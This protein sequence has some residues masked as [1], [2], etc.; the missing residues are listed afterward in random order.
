MPA[1]T[2][3]ASW[4]AKARPA[5][6]AQ[7]RGRGLE[8]L[9][10]WS[11]SPRPVRPGAWSSR[12]RPRGRG[13]RLGRVASA[14]RARRTRRRR[15]SWTPECRAPAQR[16]AAR[17]C[18]GRTSPPAARLR[19]VTSPGASCGVSRVTKARGGRGTRV[20]FVTSPK[21]P[22]DCTYEGEAPPAGEGPARRQTAAPS[23]PRPSTDPRAH[24]RRLGSSLVAD[25]SERPLGPRR[26]AR[27]HREGARR[28]QAADRAARPRG[29]GRRAR[30]VG[31]PGEG[32]GGHQPA[33][34]GAGR[35]HPGRVLPVPARRP[36]PCCSRWPPRR[37]TRPTPPRPTPS[38]PPCSGRSAASRCARCCRG[39]TT[40]ARRSCRSRPAPA[41]STARTGR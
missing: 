5:A 4:T 36:G 15:A 9:L 13:V 29:A 18:A 26:H 34:D 39:S 37:A 11:P 24:P 33:V 28:A 3:D 30:P 21:P 8:A 31:R 20:P 14:P 16:P 40:S 35:H 7:D 19:F 25:R 23:G 27:Q 2:R 10:G 38:W 12:A 22:A 32:P 41:A 6:A 1:A 17:S